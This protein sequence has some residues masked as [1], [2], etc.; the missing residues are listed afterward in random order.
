MT[1]SDMLADLRDVVAE[2]KGASKGL[3]ADVGRRVHAPILLLIAL[4][5]DLR[6]PHS[7]W[8]GWVVVA[9]FVYCAA[10]LVRLSVRSIRRLR[11]AR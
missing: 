4:Q 8:A 3:I 7:A 5:D 2:A 10:L 11:S 6:H 1:V 9:T